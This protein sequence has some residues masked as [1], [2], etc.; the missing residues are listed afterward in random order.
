MKMHS[1]TSCTSR[2]PESIEL[3]ILS[4]PE[5]KPLRNV[6]PLQVQIVQGVLRGSSNTE[7]A[8][9]LTC[10]PRTIANAL[11]RIYARLKIG[12]RAELARLF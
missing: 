6:T 4:S 9:M 11:A 3:A 10:S 5:L 2:T 8:G 1:R 12:S 7:I